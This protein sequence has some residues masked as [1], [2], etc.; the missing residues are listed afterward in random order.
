M[1]ATVF[2]LN[3]GREYD[4]DVTD[5]T[6]PLMKQWAHKI[7]ADFYEITERKFPEW[8]A[9]YEKLQIY[10][11]G[12]EMKNEWNIFIDCDALINPDLMDMTQHIPRDTV[13]HNGS[14]LATIR[15]KYDR[16]F[17]RDG[18]HI[19]SATWFCMASD[20][21]IELFKPLDDMTPEQVADSIF[22]MNHE[23][24]TGMTSIRLVEDYVMSRNI[25]QYGLKFITFQE[26][27]KKYGFEQGYFVCHAYAMAPEQ[28]L[29]TL[30]NALKGWGLM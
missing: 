26:I 11:L 30:K 17:M 2:T 28:K 9:S 24:K 8:P 29:E 6:Y 3:L 7:G 22:P 13:A 15:W 5:L 25:A 23:L 19:G 1:K 10:Q 21:C 18:R 12:Q 16:F 4:T 20:W 14:D 27:Y